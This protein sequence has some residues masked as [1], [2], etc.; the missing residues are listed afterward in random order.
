M[1]R[2]PPIRIDPTDEFHGIDRM[3]RF[4]GIPRGW[5]AQLQK[6]NTRMAKR[7][8]VSAPAFQKRIVW[9]CCAGVTANGAL[10]W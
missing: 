1:T 8:N 7:S 5:H 4:P 6:G 9:H 2:L 3:V 10:I